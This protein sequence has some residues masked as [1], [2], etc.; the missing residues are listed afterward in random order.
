MVVI[1]NLGPLSAVSHNLQTVP[2]SAVKTVF[3]EAA[4]RRRKDAV[5]LIAVERLHPGTSR[6]TLMLSPRRWT[7]ICVPVTTEDSQP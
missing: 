4:V 3:D 5:E 1:S 7:T 2:R 6:G